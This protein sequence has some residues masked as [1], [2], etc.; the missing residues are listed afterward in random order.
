MINVQLQMCSL[1]QLKQ[2]VGQ[3][4][5]FMLS[6]VC[7]FLS[8]SRDK[9]FTCALSSYDETTF[10]GIDRWPGEQV[11]SHNYRDPERFRGKV[12]LHVLHILCQLI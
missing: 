4:V 5:P 9:G 3:T 8:L 7:L 2:L 12:Y 6:C 1:H 10:S 11:H